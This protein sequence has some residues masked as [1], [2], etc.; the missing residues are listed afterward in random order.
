MFLG[1]K[2]FDN[3]FL[4]SWDDVLI[5]FILKVENL[6]LRNSLLFYLLIIFY[7]VIEILLWES[8]D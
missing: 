2:F 1:L 4:Y 6:E 8:D 3:I 5:L 7:K